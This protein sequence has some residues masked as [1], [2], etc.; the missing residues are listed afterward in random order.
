MMTLP[1]SAGQLTLGQTMDK[2]SLLNAS[3]ILALQDLV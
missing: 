1:H 2:P 3:T